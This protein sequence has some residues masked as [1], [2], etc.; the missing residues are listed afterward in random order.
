MEEGDSVIAALMQNDGDEVDHKQ[1]Q[2]GV[3]ASAEHENMGNKQQLA[4][5]A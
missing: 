5:L 2:G 4:S 1:W 3:V